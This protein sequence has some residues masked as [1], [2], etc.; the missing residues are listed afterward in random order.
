MKRRLIAQ[1]AVSSQR[2]PQRPEKLEL[3]APLGATRLNLCECRHRPQRGSKTLRR[4][5][6]G[7]VTFMGAGSRDSRLLPL[8]DQ[9]R[10]WLSIKLV[11]PVR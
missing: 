4:Q 9:T 6:F 8:W 5:I 10:V 11:S 1:G 7:H 2:Y 3:R